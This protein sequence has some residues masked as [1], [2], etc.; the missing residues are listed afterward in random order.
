MIWTVVAIVVI[1]ILGVLLFRSSSSDVVDTGTAT[2]T[3]SSTNPDGSPATGSSGSSGSNGASGSQSQMTQLDAIAANDSTLKGMLDNSSVRVPDTAVDVVLK[4]GT[5]SYMN[6]QVRGTVTLGKILGKTKVEAGYDVF[7]EMTLTSNII[8]GQKRVAL[9]NLTNAGTK[10]GSS[11][12]IG[13]RVILQSLN[14]SDDPRVS[15][16]YK[17]ENLNMRF[18]N[19]AYVVKV[20]YLDRKNG[21]PATATPSLAKDI[22]FSVKNHIISK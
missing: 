17:Y 19:V 4:G 2:S 9:F 16:Q 13:D 3:A 22:Q 21:E 12:I 20:N 1:V 8:P 11:V 14:I 18:A 15:A 5:A 6:G 7:V 10:Y